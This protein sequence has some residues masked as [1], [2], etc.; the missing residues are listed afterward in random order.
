MIEFDELRATY[1][2]RGYIVCD[3][4]ISE[5][6]ITELQ[7]V[8]N[9]LVGGA[10]G[11]RKSNQNYE[12]VEDNKTG[13]PRLE[14]VN[15]PHKIHPIFDRLIR[16]EEITSILRLLLGP[17]VR[18]QDSKLNLKAGGGSSAVEWHQ[19]WAFYPHTNDDVL[20][21]GIM[22]DGMTANNGPLMFVPASHKGPI[23]DHSSE[24]FF[25]GAVK[26]EVAAKESKHAEVVTGKAGSVTFHHCRLLHA[27]EMNHSL[28]AR[29]FLLYEVMAADAWPLAGCH[30][31][32]DDWESMND[33]LVCGKQSVIPRLCQVPVRLPQP[34]LPNATSIYAQQRYGGNRIYAD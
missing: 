9:D 30:A 13:T 28:E 15:S 18:M 12:F 10:Q 33:R 24:G 19:D 4:L 21:V 7:T 25:C 8:V 22:I 1:D 27:S 26:S 5:D 14:R 6:L 11:L 2:A 17:D 3:S 32:Y 31:L 29:R 16:S 20:A 34:I 23:Y